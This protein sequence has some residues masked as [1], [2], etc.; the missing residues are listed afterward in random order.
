MNNDELK[1]ILGRPGYG[2]A[3]SIPKGVKHAFGKGSNGGKAGGEGED[4]HMEPTSGHESLLAEAVSL[5][6]T[7]RCIVRIKFYRRRLADYS[8]AI[9][10]KAQIDA[11]V[12]GGALRDDSEKEIQL[13]DEGQFKVET[14][15]EERTEIAIEYPEVDFDNLFV[16]RTRFGNMGD[17]KE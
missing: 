9:S 16:P 10:E 1:T 8:R 7:G 5:N 11:L 13:I 15:E 2:I 3:S 6:Y 4:S 14:N 17:K 12:Y